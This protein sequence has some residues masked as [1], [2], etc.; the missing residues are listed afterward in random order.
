MASKKTYYSIP[1][2]ER[3]YVGNPIEDIEQRNIRPINTKPFVGGRRKTKEKVGFNVRRFMQYLELQSAKRV[4]DRWEVN[5]SNLSS[6]IKIDLLDVTGGEQIY[7]V[8]KGKLSSYV[9]QLSS[10][11]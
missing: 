2:K 8:N 3:S 6:F 10:G 1:N 7:E 4:A 9:R 5:S 11:T